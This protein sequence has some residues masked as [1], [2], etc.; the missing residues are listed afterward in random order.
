MRTVSGRI[1]FLTT[2]LCALVLGGFAASLYLWV[3]EGQTRA[4]EAHADLQ[5]RVFQEQ[6][7][8]EYE[9]HRKGI[10][11]DLSPLLDLL[12]DAGSSI[13]RI[14][15]PE[16]KVVF[17]SKDFDAKSTGC[18]LNTASFQTLSGDTLQ[19]SLGVPT[20]PFAVPLRQ[21]LSYFAL[22]LPAVVLLAAV[23]SLFVARRALAPLDDIRKQAERISRQNVSERIPTGPLYGE[24][25]V[26]ART[27]NDMLDRL[28]RAIQDLQNFAS[29][30]AHE[31]RTP[32]ANLRAEIETAAQKALSREEHERV[33]ASAAED[34][35][36]M[37]Q[38]VNDLLTLARMDLRQHAL[39]REPVRLRPL[40]EDARET[41]QA[42]A[43]ER[44]IL[45]EVA[46]Q[47]AI[48][49]GDAEALRRV[50]MNLLH[51]AVKY[52]RDGGRVD[53]RLE[54]SG[55]R[56]RVRVLDTGIG[57]PLEQQPKLFRRFFRV[58]QARSRD[59]GGAGLGLAI[60]KSFLEAHEGSIR[61]DS[62]P[63]QGTTF[64]VEL[65]ALTSAALAPASRA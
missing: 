64:I 15:D 16:G 43:D 24:L 48:V 6:F 61:V 47:D 27:F 3:K 39:K 55:D 26:L 50:F 17:A 63:G 56:V 41:W 62:A 11:P 30:A 35:S 28:D 18:L 22:F 14:T 10:H 42:L 51:N 36:R 25:H 57:I 5:R 21:L 49:A 44:G 1:A 7:I 34:V 20:A 31:L 65:P 37:S 54:A 40:L 29:D 45:L 60:C 59:S 12:L 4:L 32:L 58:D 46:G 52:N 33:L 38:I 13:A 2:A 9:E 8:E 19:L 53:V 23:L